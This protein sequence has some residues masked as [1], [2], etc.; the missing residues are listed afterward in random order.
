MKKKYGDYRMFVLYE[1]YE[2][3]NAQS[4]GVRN[5]FFYGYNKSQTFQ[6][7][8]YDLVPPFDDSRRTLYW[9]PDVTIGADGKAKVEF[10]N[11]GTCKEMAVSVEGMTPKS[12]PV[13]FCP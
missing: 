8:D 1:P 11:N 12:Q 5:T 6:M 10:W 2:M 3:V 13:V 9:S 7:M 4:R